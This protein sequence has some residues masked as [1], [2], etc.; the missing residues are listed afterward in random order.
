MC[1]QSGLFI[2]RVGGTVTLTPENTQVVIDVDYRSGASAEL[3]SG[4]ARVTINTAG[5][6]SAQVINGNLVG[7]MN[8]DGY[9]T[10]TWNPAKRATFARA[11]ATISDDP[12]A[13]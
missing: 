10:V 1:Q 8:Y 3:T 11:L 6:F 7:I 5:L 12:P 2:S 13:A 4:T 9:A